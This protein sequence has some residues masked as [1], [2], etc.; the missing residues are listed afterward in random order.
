MYQISAKGKRIVT[1][2][3][4]KGDVCVS[5][6]RLF[7]GSYDDFITERHVITHLLI[8]LSS[9]FTHG[10]HVFSNMISKLH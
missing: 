2:R 8:C 6:R 7:W 4:V 1:E 5:R 10:M 9:C 3:A